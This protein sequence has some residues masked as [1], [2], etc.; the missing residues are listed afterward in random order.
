MAERA[1]LTIHVRE[2]KLRGTQ[3]RFAGPRSVSNYRPF[4][5]RIDSE[6]ESERE[7]ERER[8]YCW[9]RARSRAQSGSD[10]RARVDRTEDFGR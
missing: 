5:E 1:I 7:R 6:R 8:S 2:L 9:H 3:R 10:I 4:P